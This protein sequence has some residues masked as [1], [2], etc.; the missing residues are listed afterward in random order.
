MAYFS[1]AIKKSLNGYNA[2]LSPRPYRAREEKVAPLIVWILAKKMLVRL[3]E[4]LG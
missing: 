2:T 4:D 1:L 3:A